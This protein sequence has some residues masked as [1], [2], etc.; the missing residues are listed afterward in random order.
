MAEGRLQIT[1]RLPR[2]RFMLD[3]LVSRQLQRFGPRQWHAAPP[4]LGIKAV[5]VPSGQGPRPIRSQGCGGDAVRGWGAPGNGRVPA[6]ARCSSWR[7]ASATEALRV[8]LDAVHSGDPVLTTWSGSPF[9]GGAW[10]APWT[11]KGMTA[12]NDH[13]TFHGQP[14]QVRQQRTADGCGVNS[15]LIKPRLVQ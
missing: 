1:H 3:N 14:C 15:G 8:A 4:A 11:G 12:S 9:G 13:S 10:S 5:T 6:L 2:G 7:T